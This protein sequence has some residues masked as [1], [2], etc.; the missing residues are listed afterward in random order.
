[1]G[2]SFP[3]IRSW[4]PA[5]T[6]EEWTEVDRYFTEHLLP[7]DEALEAALRSSEAAGLPSIQVSP[8]QGRFL[9]LLA[10]A[11]GAREILEIGTLGGYSAICLARSLS[12]GGRMVSLEISPEHAAVARENLARAGLA[13][14]VEVRV[15]PALES[16]SR[17]ATEGRP[18]FDL[19][20]IDAD[21]PNLAEYFDR[22]VRLSRPGSLILVDNVVRH[23][24]VQDANSRDPSVLGVRRM[25]DQIS[26]D[27]RVEA[28][29][30]PSVGVKGYDGILV[31]VVV[32]TA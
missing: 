19:V 31:A 16:L 12:A 15:G 30:Y 32:R 10:R 5:V 20:F 9:G 25:V 18:P 14:R 1:V 11:I 7:R 22:A 6:L 24:E 8:L 23:G 3:L 2:K 29:A 13:D 21:R 27:P 17:L 4:A 26:H 28:T